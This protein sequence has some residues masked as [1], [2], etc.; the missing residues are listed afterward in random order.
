MPEARE[1]HDKIANCSSYKLGSST[2]LNPRIC[3]A[4]EKL[5][6]LLLRDERNKVNQQ[7]IV[8]V[9]PSSAPYFSGAPNV[10]CFNVLRCNF[11]TLV[12]QDS[13]PWSGER[14][15]FLLKGDR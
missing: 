1:D 12:Q 2:R 5:T 10:L 8:R 6:H 4:L 13:V 9:P 15:E 14:K 7:G 11:G 3:E